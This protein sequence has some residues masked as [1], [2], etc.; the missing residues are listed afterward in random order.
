MKKLFWQIIFACL[1][2]SGSLAA[3]MANSPWSISKNGILF[4]A[5][6]GNYQGSLHGYLYDD[7]NF[8]QNHEQHFRNGSYLN[9]AYTAWTFTWLQDWQFFSDQQWLQSN[10]LQNLNVS[11]VGASWFSASLGQ[12]DPSYGLENDT[13]S[14]YIPLV[15]EAL[16]TSTFD[17]DYGLG[18]GAELNNQHWVW[19]AS[20]TGPRIS[21][22]YSGSS[23]VAL[24]S[25]F[26]YVPQHIDTEVLDF[27]LALWQQYPDGSHTISFSTT[28]EVMTNSSTAIVNTGNIQNVA[29]SLTSNASAVF[30]W[31]PFSLQAE[32]FLNATSRNQGES[33]LYFHGY[34]VTTGYFLTGESRHYNYPGGYFDGISPPRHCFGALELLA[35]LSEVDL[36]DHQIQ[37]GKE[38]NI[39]LGVGWYLNQNVMMKL[40]VIRVLSDLP[41]TNAK[42]NNTIYALRLI[43]AF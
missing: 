7:T 20:V 36:D 8:F 29:S 34:Y 17:P 5:D 2:P 39:S 24:V 35:R 27:G 41:V 11:Y 33:R 14:N 18:L 6:Q 15:N 16:P 13:A 12:I 32:Y 38:T 3:E 19:T 1:I 10:H 42:Y 4:S 26:L 21:E 40:N 9:S 25:Q 28:P 37:G 22:N 43:L 30:V 23:P 31:H